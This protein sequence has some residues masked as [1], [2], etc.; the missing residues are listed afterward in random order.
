MRDGHGRFKATTDSIANDA[1]CARLYDQGWTHRRIAD[2]MGWKNHERSFAAVR[3]HLDRI[4]SQSA[5]A[6]RKQ[7][8]ERLQEYREIALLIAREKHYAHSQGRVT[9]REDPDNPGHYIEVLDRGTN[10]QALARLESIEARLAKLF[11]ADA[12]VRQEFSGDVTVGVELTGVDP[13]DV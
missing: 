8:A 13:A 9:S 4:P 12:P 2:H 3:R 7:S 10:L 11:G 6:V 5:E 1:E